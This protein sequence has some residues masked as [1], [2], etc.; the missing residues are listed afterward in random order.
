MTS[1]IVF[2]EDATLQCVYKD[3]GLQSSLATVWLKGQ[4][5]EVII[6]G[7][8]S[9]KGEKYTSIIYHDADVYRNQMTIRNVSETDLDAYS[10]GVKFQEA[11]LAFTMDENLS[12][13]CEYSLFNILL[14]KIWQLFLTCTVN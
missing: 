9:T 11:S 3:H 1:P 2:G 8:S 4:E 13:I 7:N 10:C 12:F 6:Y 14:S 5:K